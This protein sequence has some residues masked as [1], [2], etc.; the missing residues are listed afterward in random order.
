MTSQK[1]AKNKLVQFTYIIKDEENNIIEK[2]D[3]PVQNIHGALGM[4]LID[5]VELAMEGAKEGDIVETIVS[6][7]DSFGDYHSDLV[8]SEDINNLPPQY[9]TVGANVEMTN[10]A[11]EKKAFTV[12]NI[13]NNQVTID[14]NH[15]FAGKTVKFIVTIVSIRDATNEELIETMNKNREVVH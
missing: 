1:V 5:V 7:S 13:E 6:P 10:D 8:F 9:R 15:P 11:G 12:T 3:T 14:G 2:V 4:G